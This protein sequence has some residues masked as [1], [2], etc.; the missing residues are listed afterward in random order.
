M[1]KVEG[2]NVI[3]QNEGN[4]GILKNSIKSTTKTINPKRSRLCREREQ[5]NI[6]SFFL[7]GGIL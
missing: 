7:V 4:I 6:C 3:L 1:N 5:N 2:K